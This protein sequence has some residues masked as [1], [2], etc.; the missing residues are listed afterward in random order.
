MGSD[1]LIACIVKH[2]GKEFVRN[3]ARRLLESDS[4]TLITT[5]LVGSVRLVCV[6]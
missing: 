3:V 2:A 4:G 6:P 1:C 5:Q